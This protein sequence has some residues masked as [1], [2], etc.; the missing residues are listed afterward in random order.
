MDILSHALWSSVAAKTIHKKSKT[1]IDP[2]WAG[3]WGAFPDLISFAPLA[4]VV[5]LQTVS[6]S[7]FRSFQH[8]S[9]IGQLTGFLYP[10]SHSL[11]IF[12]AVFLIVWLFRRTPAWV[13]GG[14]ALH[15]ILDI[16]T[17]PAGYYPTRFLWPLSDVHLGGISWREPWFLLVDYALLV[18]CFFLLRKEKGAYPLSTM[19]KVFAVLLALIAILTYVF[20]SVRG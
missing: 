10:A 17:H 6:G 16:G 18:L 19:K 7:D 3:F 12:L 5:I 11:V 8:S 4:L 13:M 2:W 1:K 14:W 15:V 20:T 9:S